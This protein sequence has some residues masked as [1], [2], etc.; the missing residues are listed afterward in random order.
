[1]SLVLI[2]TSFFN[3]VGCSDSTDRKIV[4]PSSVANALPLQFKTAP[5]MIDDFVDYSTENGSFEL[6]ST[7]P[8]SSRFRQQL[9]L[10]RAPRM[11]G[12][13]YAKRRYMESIGR[14]STQMWWR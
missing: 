11:C 4:K 13:S 10:E 3:M 9:W 2:S 7:H 12:A 14:S 6:I 1:M 8:C 5:E